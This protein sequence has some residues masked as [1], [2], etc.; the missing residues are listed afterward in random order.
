MK[1]KSKMAFFKKLSFNRAKKGAES[2]VREDQYK[3]ANCYYNGVGVE[4]DYR[5]AVKWYIKAAQSKFIYYKGETCDM[6]VR[7]AWYQLGLC[8]ENGTG[9]PQDDFIALRMFIE[10]IPVIPRDAERVTD[11]LKRKAEDQIKRILS[12]LLQF[13]ESEDA[14]IQYQLGWCY[15]YKASNYL[16]T[17]GDWE[18]NKKMALHFFQ[19]SAEKGYAEAAYE[20]AYLYECDDEKCALEWYKKA[21]ELGSNH[22]QY[23]L[24]EAYRRGNLGLQKNET[25][26]IEYYK[27]AALCTALGSAWFVSEAM[28]N[29]GNLY[30]KKSDYKSARFWYLKAIEPREDPWFR[31]HGIV[32]YQLGCISLA[33]GNKQSALEWF[34]KGINYDHDTSCL[35]ERESLLRK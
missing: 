28:E 29:I 11:E 3:L 6:S 2:N 24:A 8:Y 16:P 10:V 20:L 15:R 23:E 19:K 7:E 22:A 12:K 18:T 26:A 1:G 13:A 31:T 21:S 34:N 27:K 33:E 5:A 32:Y 9:V 17:K 30:Y 25:L 35:T 4:Q 14:Q